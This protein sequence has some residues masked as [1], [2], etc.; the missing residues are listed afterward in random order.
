MQPAM[1]FLFV[2]IFLI[3]AAYIAGSANRKRE[4]DALLKKLADSFGK[5]P[6][7]KIPGER[8]RHLDGY[9]KAHPEPVPG[10][11]DDITWNDLELSLVLQ[12]I[13]LVLQRTDTTRSSA[14]E[15]YL[16]YALRTAKRLSARD[17]EVL[18]YLTG[19]ASSSER[20][21]LQFLLSKLG[22]TGHYSLYDY[23]E[24]LKDAPRRG[25]LRG[26]YVCECSG[27]RPV[28]A[29]VFSVRHS[30][31]FP[32]QGGDTALYHLSAVYPAPFFLR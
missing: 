19:S 4:D 2:L 7:K 5:R 29:V 10:G 18:D 8:S 17:R 20:S 14:G 11:I 21:K 28:S 3:A 26:I 16:Y 9:Y 6:D 1:V 15:E 32:G 13:S 23:L 25:P 27:R 22:D 31:V 30:H 12:R 24:K